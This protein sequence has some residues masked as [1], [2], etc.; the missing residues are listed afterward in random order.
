MKNTTNLIKIEIN[1][2]NSAFESQEDFK[3][4]TVRL[5]KSIIECVECGGISSHNLWDVNGNRVG[6]CK[7]LD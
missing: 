1:T 3:A 7:F 6:S 4:E 2:S 5:L